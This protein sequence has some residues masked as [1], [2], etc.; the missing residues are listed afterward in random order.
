MKKLLNKLKAFLKR[1]FLQ[2]NPARDT[3]EPL[4]KQH[5][6]TIKN[7]ARTARTVAEI[8]VAAKISEEIYKRT[9]LGQNTQNTQLGENQ[10]EDKK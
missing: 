6:D 1:I 8:A 9:S 2:R 4:V 5:K 10:A 7:T 3:G